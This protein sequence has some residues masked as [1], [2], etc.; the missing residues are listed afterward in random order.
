VTPRLSAT[1]FRLIVLVAVWVL[2][3]S[4]LS[5]A[6]D[7]AADST[8][9]AVPDTPTAAVENAPLVV[10]DVR[11]LPYVFAKGELEDAGFAWQVAGGVDGFA[12]NLVAEQSVKPGAQVV[13]NGAPTGVL[14]L[15]ANPDYEAQGLPENESPYPGT[16][17]QL[18]AGAAPETA[19]EPE[20]T[21][22]AGNSAP[23]SA[24]GETSGGS[25]T[26]QAGS[27]P[28]SESD[29]AG[30]ETVVPELTA[31]PADDTAPADSTAS[32]NAE[33]GA[34]ARPV[35]FVVRGAPSEPLDE[36]PLPQ[37][38]KELAAWVEHLDGMTPAALDH[39]AYQHAWI[40]TGATFGWWR[41][42]EALRTLLE[43]DRRV[44][45]QWGIGARS[46]DLARRT[47]AEVEARSR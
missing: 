13:D 10:P 15:R 19:A 47:L 25:G 12:V 7:D 8:H 34:E 44:W 45:A 17:L 16:K 46:A 4:T 31:S 35:A 36:M 27:T 6:Q 30:A 14:R 39:F 1:A 20:T 22:G 37:R 29:A 18:L 43:V 28:G 41:G 21:D 38:A 3:T 26:A 23:E 40:V 33:A 9:T 5:L 32:E 2:G 24:T 11:G 42:A